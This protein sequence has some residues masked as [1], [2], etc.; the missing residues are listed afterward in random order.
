MYWRVGKMERILDG[1]G[2]NEWSQTNRAC[3][4]KSANI[5]RGLNASKPSGFQRA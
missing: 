2:L 4:I 5:S 3:M 1:N